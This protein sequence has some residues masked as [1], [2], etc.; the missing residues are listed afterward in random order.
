MP[1]DNSASRRKNVRFRLTKRAERTNSSSPAPRGRSRRFR[2][3]T[4]NRQGDRGTSQPAC[5]GR[6]ASESPPRG[7]SH[8]VIIIRME[9]IFVLQL[10]QQ[11]DIVGVI[12][13][14]PVRN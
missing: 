10:I 11:V 12:Q 4:G 3:G 8:A 13:L 2:C 1:P 14:K 5:T 9:L 6:Y 7:D